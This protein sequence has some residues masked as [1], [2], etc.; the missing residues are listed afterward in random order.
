MAHWDWAG[1]RG[2]G[3]RAL[4]RGGGT[5]TGTAR[6][7]AGAVG[8]AVS[9]A[10][11]TAAGLLL[12]DR[13]QAPDRDLLQLG[14]SS[15]GENL[16]RLAVAIWED[17]V[18]DRDPAA[19]GQDFHRRPVDEHAECHG[20]RSQWQGRELHAREPGAERDVARRRPVD[21]DAAAAHVVPDAG[22]LPVADT[23][24]EP[25][26]LCVPSPERRPDVERVTGRAPSAK[27]GRSWQ[28]AGPC[29]R[30]RV[31]P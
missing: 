30:E 21:V 26:V 1:G 16:D 20:P 24:V 5:P 19:V 28:Q 22:P 9:V 17:L 8:P 3:R 31:G 14:P 15:L 18:R 11:P 6:S 13:L 12:P 25:E 27:S 10:R 23:D 2:V 7:G 4:G 29:G